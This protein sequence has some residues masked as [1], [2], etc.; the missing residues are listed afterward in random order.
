MGSAAAPKEDVL[1]FG[2]A[3]SKQLVTMKEEGEK[4]GLP[5][6]FEKD[7]KMMAGVLGPDGLPP[8]PS[9]LGQNAVGRDMEK[10]YELTPDQSYENL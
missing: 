8:M 9:N 10:T 1:Q 6:F 2:D 4:T 7:K 5:A 3:G